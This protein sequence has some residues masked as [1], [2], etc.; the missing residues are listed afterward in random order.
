MKAVMYH[1]VRPPPQGLPYFRYLALDDFIAQL[2]YFAASEG[3][4]SQDDFLTA[5]ETG[6]APEKGV[7]LTFDDGMSDHLDYVL[8]ALRERGLWGLFYIATGVY[9]ND[10]LLDV[11]RIHMLL[12]RCGGDAILARLRELVRDD[13]LSDA[14]VNA[15]HSQ[16]Y[17]FQN[18]D[19]AT[20]AVKRT[21]NYYISYEWREQILDRLMAEIFSDEAALRRDFYLSPSAI[22]AL[23]D[24]GM[25]VGAHSVTHRLFSKLPVAEQET[26]IAGAFA[27]LERM[28][29]GLKLRSFCYPY[30]GDHSFTADTERLLTAHGSRCAF[31]VEPRAVGD[32]D[33]RN[34]PQALPRFDCNRFPHGASRLGGG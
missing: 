34:R 31:S 9:E 33:L 11:H 8:P 18:N 21:L 22:C 7:V 20:D 16:P 23:Q 3:F 14:E 28:T 19:A 10:R 1:Y 13:M 15:F 24:A 5:L 29:G 6:S 4:V 26:E 32:A 17:R 25:L 12:G 2:D 27:A 30:G